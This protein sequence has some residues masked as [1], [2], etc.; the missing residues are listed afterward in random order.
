MNSDHSP[1][2][3]VASREGGGGSEQR[4]GSGD[5]GLC[6]AVALRWVLLADRGHA[7]GFTRWCSR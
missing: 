5:P 1:R 4:L 2:E 3:L 6:M 7:G